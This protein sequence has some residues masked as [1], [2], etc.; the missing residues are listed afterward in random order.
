MMEEVMD[1]N[2]FLEARG[3]S[4]PHTVGHSMMDSCS[5]NRP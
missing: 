1:L 3:A 2:G 5:K 4:R